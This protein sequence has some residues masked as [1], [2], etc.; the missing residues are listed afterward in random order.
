MLSFLALTN[1]FVFPIIGAESGVFRTTDK[2]GWPWDMAIMY[3]FPN[4]THLSG[5]G[6][7]F[8]GLIPNFKLFFFS[9]PCSVPPILT[10]NPCLEGRRAID[11]SR[12]WRIFCHVQFDI[13]S[14]GWHKYS[15]KLIIIKTDSI[16]II[17]ANTP[18][19]IN[20]CR[21]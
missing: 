21:R 3:E 11:F 20:F 2:R 17:R 18:P 12:I 4:E 16:Y 5:Y 6:N 10:I 19:A 13:Q 14:I 15:F 7:A 1:T 9:Y 8:Y